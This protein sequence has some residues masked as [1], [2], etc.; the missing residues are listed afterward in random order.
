[1]TPVR[2]HD[3]VAV[4]DASDGCG[5]GGAPVHSAAGERED[6]QGGEDENPQTH[7]HEGGSRPR[8]RQVA[9]LAELRAVLA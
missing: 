7:V 4:E 9:V 3:R 1:M 8:P 2:Q 5:G 6:E